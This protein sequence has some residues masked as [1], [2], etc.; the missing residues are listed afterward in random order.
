MKF[1]WDMDEL[2]EFGEQLKDFSNFDAYAQQIVKELAKALQDA[3]FR[4]TPVLTG[5]L[6]ASW[7]GEENCSFTVK[8]FGYGYKVTLYNKAVSLRPQQK[9]KNYYYGFA[10]NDGH[11]TPSGGWVVGKFFVE[12]SVAQTA[13]SFQLEQIIMQKLQKWWDSV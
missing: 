3:L 5:N 1:D 9:Y 8:K 7:G 12:A 2:T 11:A 6:C 4:N 13:N 10:V